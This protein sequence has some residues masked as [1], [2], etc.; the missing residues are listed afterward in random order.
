MILVDTSVWIDHF[1]AADAR[2]IALLTAGEAATH[3]A[4][5]ETAADDDA[6][7]DIARTAP[8]LALMRP[9]PLDDVEP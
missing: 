4:A 1:R 3:A 5:S 6:G 2:L 9:L 8:V 7:R